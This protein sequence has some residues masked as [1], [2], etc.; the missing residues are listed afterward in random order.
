MQINKGCWLFGHLTKQCNK[1]TG[2]D[3]ASKAVKELK[4]Q[5]FNVLNADAESFISKEK[6]DVIIAPRVLDHLM[7]FDGLFKCCSKNLKPEGKLIIIDDNP[8]SFPLLFYLR[9]LHGYSLG[10]HYDIT[11]KP[12][13][14]Y[15]KN[16]ASKYDFEIEKT[17]YFSQIKKIKLLRKILP[18][19]LLAN[20]L[21]LDEY[22]C[23][24]KKINLNPPKA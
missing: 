18:K 7:N 17:E 11:I 5:G 19:K 13:P 9:R 10:S 16:F 20:D 23:V 1:A 14:N 4:K 6:F 3:I 21:L 24:L 8:V 15:F 2:I 22:L 12:V